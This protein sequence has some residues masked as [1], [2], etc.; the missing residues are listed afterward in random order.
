MKITLMKGGKTV[1]REYNVGCTKGK[2]YWATSR[3]GKNI[4]Q[5]GCTK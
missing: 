3:K 1:Y 4:Y 5:S 2:L